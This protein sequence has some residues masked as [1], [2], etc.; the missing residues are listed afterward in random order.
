MRSTSNFEDKPAFSEV[1]PIGESYLKSYIEGD[2][3]RLDVVYTRFVNIAKQEAVA[4]TL[5]PSTAPKKRRD[6]RVACGSFSF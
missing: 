2:I 5:L 6:F 3:D 4:E 1:A